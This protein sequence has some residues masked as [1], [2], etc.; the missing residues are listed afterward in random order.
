MGLLLAVE[1]GARVGGGGWVV[2]WWLGA[3]CCLVFFFLF[4]LSSHSMSACLLCA[5][6][7][8]CLLMEDPVVMALFCT[9]CRPLNKLGR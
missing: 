6:I 5:Q 2:G 3:W 4:M 1:K 7:G 9:G 8:L